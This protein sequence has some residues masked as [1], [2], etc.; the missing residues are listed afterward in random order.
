MKKDFNRDYATAAFRLWALRGC[1]TY[2]QEAERIK[3]SAYEKAKGADPAKVMAFA[4]AELDKRGAELCD[5]MACAETFR[6]L[7]ENGKEL[8]CEAVKAVYMVEP[9]RE[10]RRD[11]ISKRVLRFAIETP[12]SERQVYRWLTQARNLFALSRGLRVEDIDGWKV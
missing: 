9:W 12:A 3:V 7:D 5:I 10:P 4:E 2:E 8:I 6:I 11:E 1:P